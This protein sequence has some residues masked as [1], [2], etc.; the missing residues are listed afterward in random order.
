MHIELK[1]C[2][3][4]NMLMMEKWNACCSKLEVIL[5]VCIGVAV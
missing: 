1:D 2:Q 3:N 5:K 4:E